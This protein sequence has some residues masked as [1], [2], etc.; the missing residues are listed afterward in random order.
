MKASLCDPFNTVLQSIKDKILVA[1]A[2]FKLD[3]EPKA[4]SIVVKVNGAVI[5]ESATTWQYDATVNSIRFSPQAVP[6]AD[7]KI[8]ITYDPKTLL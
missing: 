6:A 7:D 8:S 3:R 1:S 4:G 2:V 5:A